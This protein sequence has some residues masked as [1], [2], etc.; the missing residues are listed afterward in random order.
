M[1]SLPPCVAVLVGLAFL[2]V[3]SYSYIFLFVILYIHKYILCF[4]FFLVIKKGLLKHKYE[5]ICLLARERVKEKLII[6]INF[7]NQFTFVQATTKYQ[8]VWN[9]LPKI[10]VGTERR[11]RNIITIM[12]SI[13]DEPIPLH[14]KS[15]FLYN[16]WLSPIHTLHS[17][18]WKTYEMQYSNLNCHS[19]FYHC[20]FSSKLLLKNSI[21]ATRVS[22]EGPSQNGICDKFTTDMTVAKNFVANRNAIKIRSLFMTNLYL[23]MPIT[24][25]DKFT[26]N[27][28]ITK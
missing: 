24:I 16:K 22:V 18:N 25:C 13:I 20:T 26:T 23:C 9:C 12:C 4:F 17:L 15:D 8:H 2:K 28:T 11:L 27:L 3:C 5:Y 7:R 1:D 14:L 19:L 21:L 10:F 6:D